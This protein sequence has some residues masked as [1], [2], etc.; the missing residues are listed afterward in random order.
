MISTRLCVQQAKV[1]YFSSR[2][3]TACS[4]SFQDHLTPEQGRPLAGPRFTTYSYCCSTNKV[5]YFLTTQQK[6]GSSQIHIFTFLGHQSS[7]TAKDS[8]VGLKIIT[9]SYSLQGRPTVYMYTVNSNVF[10]RSGLFTKN[11]PSCWLDICH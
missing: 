11:Q 10:R 5:T 7:T 2:S 4:P 9:L 8:V 3:P 6:P 1:T